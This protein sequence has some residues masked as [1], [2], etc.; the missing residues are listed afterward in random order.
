MT[1]ELRKKLKNWHRECEFILRLAS[2]ENAQGEPL[3]L[4]PLPAKCRNLECGAKTRSG[5]PCKIKLLYRNGRCKFHGG[6]S[7][8][9]KTAEGKRRSALNTGKSYE[10]ILANRNN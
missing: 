9:P 3:P 7:T 2:S 5:K 8:G 1:D 6:P 4:P 10:E